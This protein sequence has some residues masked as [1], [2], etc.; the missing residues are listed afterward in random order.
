M[1]IEVFQPS[2]TKRVIPLE[3]VPTPV[4][5]G[6][7]IPQHVLVCSVSQ[8]LT[9]ATSGDVM[10][11]YIT[12]DGSTNFVY[13]LTDMALKIRSI[14]S[15]DITA[16]SQVA[17]AHQVTG[18]ANESTEFQ[19]IA[20]NSWGVIGDGE[21]AGP[22]ISASRIYVPERI[23]SYPVLVTSVPD[24]LNMTLRSGGG[25]VTTNPITVDLYARFLAFD[26]QQGIRWPINTP[27]IV[28]S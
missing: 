20:L 25:G 14:S 5:A 10:L 11:I 28:V 21:I 23:P 24:M 4:Q 22:T 12:I 6:T 7:G 19:Y 2:V 17:S 3:G 8:D 1:A 18:F 9:I 15:A 16:F 13:Q 26:Q 27:S